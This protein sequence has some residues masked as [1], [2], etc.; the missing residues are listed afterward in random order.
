MIRKLSDKIIDF[1]LKYAIVIDLFLGCILIYGG[2]TRCLIDAKVI[3]DTDFSSF[4]S[5]I[6]SSLISLLGFL[7]AAL[8]V[9]ITFKSNLKAK[10]TAEEFD[11]LNELDLIIASKY[12]DILQLFKSALFEYLI[13]LAII[14]SVWLF[15]SILDREI[16]FFILLFCLAAIFTIL[17]RTLAV[18]F[19]LLHLD[20]D[21]IE[22]PIDEE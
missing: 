7:I 3:A 18:L 8:T 16:Q 9:I 22:M 4:Y 12:P 17:L 19:K 10:L 20:S 2:K 11:R 15:T 13:L 1:Y 6:T 14:S 5:N 21:P